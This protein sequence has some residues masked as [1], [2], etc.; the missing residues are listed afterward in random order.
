MNEDAES[1]EGILR[2]CDMSKFDGL[3][4]MIHSPG[5]LPEAAGDIIRVCRTYSNSFRVIVPNMAMSA[6]TLLAMGSDAIAMSDTSKLGPIDPQMVYQTKE[7]AFMR[8]AQS[9]ILAFSS[10]VTEAN[11]L[12]G[13][14]QPVAAHLHLLTKQDPSWILECHRAR[15]ATVKLAQRVL[16]NGMLKGKSDAEVEK[17]ANDFLKAGDEESHGRRITPEEAATMGLTIERID[18]NSALWRDIWELYVRIDN[19][20]KARA[21]AKYFCSDSGGLE[22]KVKQLSGSM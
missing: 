5:G 18:R 10:L 3:E 12:A 8:A 14:G 21:L 2:S 13:Q 17:V 4:L 9:F 11:G 22:M 20:T 16:K 6:A 15:N 1:I 7:G 19:Y